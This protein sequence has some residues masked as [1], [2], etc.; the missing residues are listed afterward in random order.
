MDIICVNSLLV[1]WLLFLIF[2][3]S[4][5]PSLLL[6]RE[7]VGASPAVLG[8]GRVPVGTVWTPHITPATRPLIPVHGD[9]SHI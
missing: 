6:L 3:I 9:L 8:L 1:T 5:W 2:V 7:P 4:R